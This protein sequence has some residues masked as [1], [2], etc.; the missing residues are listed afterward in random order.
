MF[1]II[2]KTAQIHYILTKCIGTDAW[3]LGFFYT[4]PLVQRSLST[5]RNLLIDPSHY[6]IIL[7]DTDCFWTVR[8]TKK[9]I[10]CWGY[11]WVLVSRLEMLYWL[12]QLSR[13]AMS[14]LCRDK[15]EV[16]RQS[17]KDVV[18]SRVCSRATHFVFKASAYI[19]KLGLHI[20]GQTNSQAVHIHYYFVGL[21]CQVIQYIQV[22]TGR[23]TE[24]KKMHLIPAKLFWTLLGHAV[25]L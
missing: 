25:D 16:F 14:L 4:L 5:C 20:V 2:R 8:N 12:F 3:V 15:Q 18:C 23:H 22:H 6:F 11:P 24:I 13:N 10:G 17:Y 19:S 9:H 1:W 7:L 21:L